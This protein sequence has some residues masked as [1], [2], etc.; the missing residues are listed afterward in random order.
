MNI[1]STF[2]G[3][4]IGKKILSRNVRKLTTI[5]LIASIVIGL[6]TS[7][8]W[9]NRVFLDGERRFWNAI[10]TSMSTPS[11]VRTLTQGGSGN[12]VVQ[13]FRFHYAP[14][15][16]IENNVEF[17]TKSATED[18]TVRTEGRV[19]PEEQYLRY[20]VFDNVDASGD[21][22]S[23]ID[24]LIGNWAFQ[25]GQ[26]P[27]V[28]AEDNR[29]AFLSEYVSLAVFG[30]YDAEYRAQIIKELR[31]NNVYS[32]Q[33]DRPIEQEVE[34]EDGTT[35]EVLVYQVRVQLQDYAR[36]LNDSF[37][38]A[39]FGSFPP[40]DP[41]NYRE[42]QDVTSQITVSKKNGTIMQIE[43]GGRQEVYSNYGVIKN[44]EKPGYDR[45]VEELQAAVQE[46]L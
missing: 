4:A 30:N 1:V 8:F 16:V 25:E 20:T 41:E 31:D 3:S 7:A 37:M 36:I 17:T 18:L 11:V 24:D 26:G 29:I 42:G 34:N 35:E 12:Q 9:Y 40:L 21:P 19:Y 13:D 15:R 5:M 14:Q 6:I 32:G 10:N 46:R 45:T 38:K 28:P 39:G 27:N 43:F 2:E 33:L 44:I 22:I 23:N